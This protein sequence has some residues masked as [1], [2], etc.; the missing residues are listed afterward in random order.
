MSSCDHVG[1]RT[2][3]RGRHELDAC[4]LAAPE[5]V[6]RMRPNG[7]HVADRIDFDSHD[8]PRT[9]PAGAAV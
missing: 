3:L 5:I 1:C 2:A 8:F 4:L 6:G 7:L 9:L